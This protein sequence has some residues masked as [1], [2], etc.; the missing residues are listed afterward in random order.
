MTTMWFGDDKH[1]I[2]MDD[3]SYI[4]HVRAET[5]KQWNSEFLFNTGARDFSNAQII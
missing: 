5:Q 3:T 4:H 2:L 1:D